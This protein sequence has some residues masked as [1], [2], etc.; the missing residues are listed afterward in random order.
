[1]AIRVLNRFPGANVRVLGVRAEG[2]EPEVN[3]TADP[4]GGT[5]ALWFHFRVDDPSPP[6]TPPAMLTL[7]LRYFET[8]SEAGDPAAL[9]PV[10][11]E[12]G[13]NW[14]RLKPP[15]VAKQPDGQKSL[16]WSIPYPT[17]GTEVAL[18]YP[19]FRDELALLLEHSNDYW[20]E[21]GVGLTQ[22]GRV[23]TRLRNDV[24]EGGAACPHPRGL[25]VI[26]RQHA[27]ETPGSWV[28]D[29]LLTALARAK[30][31]NWCVWA[32]PFANLDG[33]VAGDY[34]RGVLPN[35]L[36][37][38]WGNPPLRHEA[39]VLQRDMQRWATQCRPDL[40][41]DL[42]A[43]GACAVEGVCAAVAESATPEWERAS[44]A[45]AN[46]FKQALSPDLAADAFVRKAEEPSRAGTL[47]L[48][49]FVRDTLGCSA[50]LLETPYALCRDT[51]M[52]PKQY[53][54]IG[55]RIA[56]AI[57]TRR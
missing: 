30:P 36:S 49:D 39:L 40:V 45:W 52:A 11:H 17:G 5:E 48:S 51:L 20:H 28:L 43:P 46:V 56:R 6:A 53:R 18:C 15:T 22:D 25:Y 3:F 14:F 8:L 10:T 29:G 41:L 1:M 55:H 34:G 57:L 37:R 21:E 50:L 16:S 19:Y 35:G 7:T 32:V 13:K 33:V 2:P 47:R 54:D 31:V 24:A 27:G 4:H 38:A 44:Q 12:A 23:L 9:R 26:A 42:Q